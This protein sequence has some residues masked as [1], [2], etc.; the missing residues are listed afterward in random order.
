MR[1]YADALKPFRF[2]ASL[3]RRRSALVILTKRTSSI[4]KR[5]FST[6]GFW[7]LLR[8]GTVDVYCKQLALV[9]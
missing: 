2:A 1:A 7:R 4:P 6:V 8:F 5:F 9:N 3:T